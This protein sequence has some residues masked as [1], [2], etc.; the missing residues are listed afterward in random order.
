MGNVIIP[1]L[2]SV[3]AN[4]MLMRY[5][6]F[7]DQYPGAEV[8]GVD[9]SPTQP[10]WIP[11]NLKFEHD[12]VSQPWTYK[13]D[14]FDYIHMRWLVGNIED[15]YELFKEIF[16]AL[17]PGGYFESKESSA[18]I[19]SDDGTVTED[20][21]LSQWGKVFNQAGK[22]WGRSFLIVEDD[23]QRKAMEAA[24]F[25]DIKE[26]PFKAR[27]NDRRDKWHMTNLLATG[28]VRNVASR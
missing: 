12:D 3:N 10:Q 13:P 6:D 9:V 17:K 23:I 28:T 24:G 15:W 18:I 25:V 21:A 4:P 5:S 2:L 1:R 11:P 22:K 26:Y 27:M 20:S 19:T 14:T 7:A 8:V 16:R